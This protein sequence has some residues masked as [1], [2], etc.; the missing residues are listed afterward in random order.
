MERTKL[1]LPGIPSRR[2]LSENRL[3]VRLTVSERTSLRGADEV[4]FKTIV[5]LCGLRGARCTRQ[6]IGCVDRA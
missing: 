3:S 4:A 1:L 6:F 5:D 2:I